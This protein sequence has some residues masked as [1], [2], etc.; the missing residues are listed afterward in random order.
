M[1]RIRTAAIVFAALATTGA[2]AAIAEAA[3]VQT[4]SVGI[5]QSK[6]SSASKPVPIGLNVTLGTDEDTGAYPP[7]TSETVVFLPPRLKLNASRFKSCTVAIVI[8]KS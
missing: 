7:T 2:A 4:L 5:T 8:A 1:T 6:A 3:T